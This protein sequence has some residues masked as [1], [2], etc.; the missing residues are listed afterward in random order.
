VLLPQ[1]HPLPVQ[2]RRAEM[3]YAERP[4]NTRPHSRCVPQATHTAP[5]K[6]LEERSEPHAYIKLRSGYARRN[7]C[8]G[9]AARIV[10]PNPPNKLQYRFLHFNIFPQIF[11]DA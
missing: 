4:E 5:L 11:F 9:S 2:R 7:P 10:S 8:L 3:R 6:L 1:P